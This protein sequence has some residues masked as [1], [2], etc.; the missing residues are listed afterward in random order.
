MNEVSWLKKYQRGY[1]LVAL[2]VGV[3]VSCWA[4]NNN[5]TSPEA[6]VYVWLPDSFDTHMAK[7]QSMGQ[8]EKDWLPADT[9]YLR[10]VYRNEF[11]F[12]KVAQDF[13]ALNATLI[14][15]GTDSRSL[16]RPSVCLTG[17]GWTIEEKTRRTIKTEG[18]P[19][20]VMDY[21]LQRYSMDEITREPRL[22]AD[23]KP[24]SI[25]AHYVYWWVGHQASTASDRERV[26][27]E[28]WGSVLKGRRERWAYPSVM[29]FVDPRKEAEDGR[30][31]AQ[32]RIFSY[33]SQFAPKF[34][35][36]LGAQ[37]MSD[38]RKLK[39]V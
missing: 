16:H 37:P 15:A 27:L 18:G 17:Q 21:A 35:K 32:N 5:E 6:G 31:E 7:E 38:T 24:I 39:D 10:M 13:L 34:Q 11:E 14:V 33:I 2:V 1:V 9:T 23:G 28:V 22:G 30:R 26:W 36:S 8:E 25:R 19:L 12:N 20:E 3:V 4:F 29:L